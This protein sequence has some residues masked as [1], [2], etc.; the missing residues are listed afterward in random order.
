M[1]SGG[2]PSGQIQGSNFCS[3]VLS[4]KAPFAICSC[5]SKGVGCYPG[6]EDKNLADSSWPSILAFRDTASQSY[7]LQK[8]RGPG[9]QGGC[10]I[11]SQRISSHLK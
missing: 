11:T 6:K 5:F 3:L 9:T 4:D 10:A 8:V 7:G 1:V 2:S